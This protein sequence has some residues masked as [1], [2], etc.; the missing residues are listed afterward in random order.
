M[1]NTNTTAT[2]FHDVDLTSDEHN[3]CVTRKPSITQRIKNR[4]RGKSQRRHHTVAATDK[5]MIIASISSPVCLNYS[6]QSDEALESK[7]SILSCPFDIKGYGEFLMMDEFK[8]KHPKKLSLM[9]FL[10]EGIMIFTS[11]TPNGESY[12]FKGSIRMEDLCLCPAEKK[13]VLVV[14]DHTN[15]KR[16]HKEISFELHTLS[17]YIQVKWRLAIEKCLWKQFVKVR[18]ESQGSQRHSQ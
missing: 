13:T 8:V 5:E 10:Y 11:R 16:F 12:Y 1:E 2:V 15:S 9:V 17:E 4:F 3:K 6:T 7:Y 18:Q 14:K